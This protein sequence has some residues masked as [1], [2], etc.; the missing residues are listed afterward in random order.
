MSINAI[1]RR[2]QPEAIFRLGE[3]TPYTLV[4]H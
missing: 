3:T 1:N 4:G 2:L